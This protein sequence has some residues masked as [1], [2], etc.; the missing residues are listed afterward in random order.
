MHRQHVGWRGNKSFG[1]KVDRGLDTIHKFGASKMEATYNLYGREIGSNLRFKKV[2]R[3]LAMYIGLEN[4]LT[5]SLTT[6]TIPACEQLR[7]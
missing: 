6:F 4:F 2:M 3:E 7:T 5:A 1:E